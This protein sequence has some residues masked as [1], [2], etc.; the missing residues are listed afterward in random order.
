MNCVP[1][2]ALHPLLPISL[3]L[4]DTACINGNRN[5]SEKGY[6][7][8][9]SA[10]EGF[11]GHLKNEMFYNRLWKYIFIEQFIN[12]LDDYMKCYNEKRIKMSL[13]GISPVK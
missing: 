4:A 1:E 10:C 8:D 2:K 6:S 9:D 3:G 5:C 12:I 11:F 13:G 7:P